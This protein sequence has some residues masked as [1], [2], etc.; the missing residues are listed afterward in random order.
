MSI[1][2]KAANAQMNI[3]SRHNINYAFNRATTSLSPLALPAKYSL[4][5]SP[6]ALT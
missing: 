1:L 4:T 3:F 6:A 2:I 5:I